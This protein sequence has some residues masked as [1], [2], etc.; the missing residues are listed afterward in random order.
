MPMSLLPVKPSLLKRK[1]KLCSDD[2]HARDIYLHYR[3]RF[4]Y[5]DAHH[6]LLTYADAILDALAF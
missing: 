6:H 1:K 2:A 5:N 3:S 4:R